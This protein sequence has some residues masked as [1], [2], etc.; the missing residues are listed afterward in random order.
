MTETQEFVVP[1]SIPMTSAATGFVLH[2]E[3]SLRRQIAMDTDL[4]MTTHLEFLITWEDELLLQAWRAEEALSAGPWDPN[5]I[6]KTENRSTHRIN[7]NIIRR[8]RNATNWPWPRD[9]NRKQIAGSREQR[10]HGPGQRRM[11]GCGRTWPASTRREFRRPSLALGLG[12][13]FQRRLAG[14]GGRRR[15]RRDPKNPSGRRRQRSLLLNPSRSAAL[16][17]KRGKKWRPG[18]FLWFSPGQICGWRWATRLVEAS[19]RHQSVSVRWAWAFS[20]PQSTVDR[21]LIKK[22]K[23]L[24]HASMRPPARTLQLRKGTFFLQDA[25]WKGFFFARC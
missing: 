24:T 3:H 4:L 17:W 19:T 13:D 18:A 21:F 6:A 11:R 15:R 22:K 1:R 7:P 12:R 9:T 5:Q 20:R 10:W 2:A 8:T 14:A 23:Q 16:A 25:N